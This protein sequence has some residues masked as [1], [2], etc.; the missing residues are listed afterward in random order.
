LPVGLSDDCELLG[1]RS[2]FCEMFGA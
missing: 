1:E 2:W